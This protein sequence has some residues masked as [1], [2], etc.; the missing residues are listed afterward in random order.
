MGKNNICSDM[1]KMIQTIKSHTSGHKL[2]TSGGQKE[3]SLPC[4]ILYMVL[5]L[6]SEHSLSSCL[7]NKL[8]GLNCLLLSI[9]N[10]LK[11]SRLTLQSMLPLL[12]QTPPKHILMSFSL[13]VTPAKSAVEL[14]I[15]LC[16][17]SLQLIV[18]TEEMDGQRLMYKFV[19][20]G[21]CKF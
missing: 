18:F 9:S 5:C 10:N 1:I 16:L 13:S 4:I 21:W 17:S 20:K 6:F 15:L 7:K 3:I 12:P 2:I 14:L 11:H 19:I 8:L